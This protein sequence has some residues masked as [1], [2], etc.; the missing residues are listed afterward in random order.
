[1]EPVSPDAALAHLIAADP[2]L[3]R[4]GVVICE[5]CGLVIDRDRNAARNLASLAKTRTPG[6]G[7]A[8]PA[9]GL[10]STI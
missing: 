6:P 3:V 2:A 7:A 5:H 4:A 8:G 10:A 9:A 1:V